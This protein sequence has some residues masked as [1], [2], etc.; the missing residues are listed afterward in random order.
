MTYVVV[1][2]VVDR[3][4]LGSREYLHCG[5]PF[6]TF[7]GNCISKAKLNRVGFSSFATRFFTRGRGGQKVETTLVEFARR[8][9]FKLLAPYSYCYLL[10]VMLHQSIRDSIELTETV[11]RTH[12]YLSVEKSKE[13]KFNSLIHMHRYASYLPLDIYL[14]KSR[15]KAV[16]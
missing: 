3:R 16:G 8:G 7:K 2:I 13:C 1:V 10:C 14:V 5:L 12:L 11:Q 9:V 15:N 4:T 6:S